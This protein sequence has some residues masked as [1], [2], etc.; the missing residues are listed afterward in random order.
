VDVVVLLCTCCGCA[1]YD[2]IILYKMT[3]T[4]DMEDALLACSSMYVASA[5]VTYL[6]ASQKSRLKKR[7]HRVWIYKKILARPTTAWSL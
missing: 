7:K 1:V 4:D 2:L 5:T 3:S 6:Y